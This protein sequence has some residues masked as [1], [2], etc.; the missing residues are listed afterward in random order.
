VHS[1]GFLT[2]L[3]HPPDFSLSSAR[4]EKEYAHARRNHTGY[5]SHREIA[6]SAEEA[7]LTMMLPLLVLT[8]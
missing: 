7:S 4:K 2:N 1:L 3:L 8:N 5:S 6:E